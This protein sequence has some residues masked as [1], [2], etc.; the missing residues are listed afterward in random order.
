M[1]RCTMALAVARRRRDAKQLVVRT[2]LG[3]ELREVHNA[4]RITHQYINRPLTCQQAV[5]SWRR[6]HR[7]YGSCASNILVGRKNGRV[8][9]PEAW[10]WN[11]AVR[12]AASAGLW[13]GGE[14]PNI[15]KISYSWVIIA[16]SSHRAVTSVQ[17]ASRQRTSLIAQYQR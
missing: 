13:W 9:S 2:I 12:Y 1:V 11:R 4:S 7:S 16:A 17:I 3:V 6:G 10:Q 14:G 5:Y 15:Q 8:T